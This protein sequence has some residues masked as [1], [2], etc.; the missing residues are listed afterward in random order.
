ML[1]FGKW[2]TLSLSKKHP[3]GIRYPGICRKA[4][5]FIWY[6]ALDFIEIEIENKFQTEGENVLFFFSM[7]VNSEGSLV[8]Q[9]S[10]S[11]GKKRLNG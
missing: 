3:F 5:E 6:S 11:E 1:G 9:K 10:K 8:I 2:V 7:D 4:G